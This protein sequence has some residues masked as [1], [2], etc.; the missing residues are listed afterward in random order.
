MKVLDR[1]SDDLKGVEKVKALG[2]KGEVSGFR[3]RVVWMVV[4]GVNVK[5]RLEPKVVAKVVLL[6]LRGFWV[7]ELAL[8]AIE[9]GD[10]DKWNEED[11]LQVLVLGEGDSDDSVSRGVGVRRQ[12][13]LPL[14][15]NRKWIS[16]KRTEKRS[17]KRQNR[18]RNGRA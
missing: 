17:Q 12:G 14:S 2:A 18:A 8:D 5:A 6:L 11:A 9:Y 10:Q 1:G 3:V 7:E 4:D 13:L 16:M 15:L